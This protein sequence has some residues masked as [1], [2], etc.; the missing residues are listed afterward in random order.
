MVKEKFMGNSQK[1]TEIFLAVRRELLNTHTGQMLAQCPW[2]LSRE[3][4]CSTAALT[5]VVHDKEKT[6]PTPTNPAV[7][8]IPMGGFCC[9]NIVPGI[10]MR[11]CTGSYRSRDNLKIAFLT[12]NMHFS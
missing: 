6:P 12:L 3:V 7:M 10:Q 5:Q 1:S 4:L 8:T 9:Y 2:K 11:A